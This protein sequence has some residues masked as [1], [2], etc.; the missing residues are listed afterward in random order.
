MS[1]MP[2]GASFWSNQPSDEDDVEFALQKIRMSLDKATSA[3]QMARALAHRHAASALPDPRDLERRRS[4]RAQVILRPSSEPW[5][6]DRRKWLYAGDF[7]GRRYDDDMFFDVHAQ[8]QVF[9]HLTALSGRD[10]I[11]P[12]MPRRLRDGDVVRTCIVGPLVPSGTWEVGGA[13]LDS[14][15]F[16]HHPSDETSLHWRHFDAPDGTPEPDVV[17]GKR[18]LRGWEQRWGALVEWKRDRFLLSPHLRVLAVLEPELSLDSLREHRDLRRALAV[19]L[20]RAALA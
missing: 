3:K 15:T 18:M 7:I 12:R 4:I 1:E 13:Y 10:C 8:V 19:A 20:E 16:A 2:R 9:R 5:K 17:Y 14:T 11:L 6:S